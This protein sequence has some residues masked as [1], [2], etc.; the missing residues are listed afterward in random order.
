MIKSS[1]N[2]Y[3]DRIISFNAQC[4]VSVYLRLRFVTMRKNTVST[5]DLQV[6][7]YKCVLWKY[8]WLTVKEIWLLWHFLY[9]FEGNFVC[10]AFL[11]FYCNAIHCKSAYINGFYCKTDRVSN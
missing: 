10:P 9:D 11:Q 1:L 6:K 3:F 5:M 8:R 4:I 7:L 2:P